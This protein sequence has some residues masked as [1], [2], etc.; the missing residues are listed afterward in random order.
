MPGGSGASWA[1]REPSVKEPL[2]RARL[3]NSGQLRPA[4]P[5]RQPGHALLVERLPSAFRV[6]IGTDAGHDRPEC[7]HSGYPLRRP[8]WPCSVVRD[9]KHHL[10]RKAPAPLGIERLGPVG[11]IEHVSHHGSK[12][13]LL[14][15]A[16]QFLELWAG[17]LHHEVHPADAACLIWLDPR[18]LHDGDH[19]AAFSDHGCRSSQDS[20]PT[21]SITTSTVSAKSSN[22]S[23][24]R[25]TNCSAPSSVTRSRADPWPVAMT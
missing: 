19:D 1:Q 12:L 14:G 10:P 23:R 7:S 5:G 8:R 21:K 16:G 20:P 9:T 13:S 2:A 24:S 18:I 22:R 25:S 17:R 11:E 15:P 4:S 6:H 3:D